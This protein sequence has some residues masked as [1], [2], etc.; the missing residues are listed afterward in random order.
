MG[1]LYKIEHLLR[2]KTRMDVFDFSVDFFLV[3]SLLCLWLHTTLYIVHI[4]VFIDW[5][6]FITFKLSTEL[7]SLLKYLSHRGMCM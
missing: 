1:W 2:Y 3:T 4:V 6:N 5:T 7:L